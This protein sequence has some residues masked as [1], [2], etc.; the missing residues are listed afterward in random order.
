M[1]DRPRKL[2]GTRINSPGVSSGTPRTH[3]FRANEP[4]FFFFLGAQSWGTLAPT[5]STYTE[6]G[7]VISR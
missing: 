5:S 3:C 4:Y 7:Y 1:L 6:C 2:K